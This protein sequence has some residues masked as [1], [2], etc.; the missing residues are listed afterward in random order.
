MA[1]DLEPSVVVHVIDSLRR[2][3]YG[4][5]GLGKLAPRLI[6][7]HVRLS[8]HFRYWCWTTCSSINRNW[9]GM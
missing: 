3:Q 5:Q 1:K 9:L 2:F 8:K 6:I 7:R 4:I